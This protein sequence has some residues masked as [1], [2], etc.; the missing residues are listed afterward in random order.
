[1]KL[2]VAWNA[3]TQNVDGTPV[4]DLAGYRVYDGGVLVAETVELTADLDLSDGQHTLT[5]RAHNRMGGESADSEVLIV[6]ITFP[7]AP[8]NLRLVD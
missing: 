2:K 4:T 3:V 8:T 1:M 5:V 7:M 6:R